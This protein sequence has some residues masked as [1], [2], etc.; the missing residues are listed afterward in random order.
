MPNDKHVS[1]WNFRPHLKPRSHWCWG[2]T[3]RLLNTS[4]TSLFRVMKCQPEL[5]NSRG[6]SWKRVYLISQAPSGMWSFI[7]SPWGC[8]RW[9]F[10]R[11]TPS[12]LGTRP[13]EEW[14]NRGRG[15]CTTDIRPEAWSSWSFF[16]MIAGS[17]RADAR[18]SESIN[19]FGGPSYPS[20]SP[21]RSIIR[22]WILSPPRYSASRFAQA[23][24][25]SGEGQLVSWGWETSASL[26]LIDVYGLRGAKRR[27]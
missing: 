6:T 21:N 25:F 20:Y 9:W 1:L 18:L 19:A 16:S 11:Q 7:D 10:L 15:C 17:L 26:N 5:V 2:A 12:C 23:L 8:D 3:G 22:S 24:G 13:S 27:G 14:I 4:F